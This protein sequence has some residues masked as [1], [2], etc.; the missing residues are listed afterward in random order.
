MSEKET[1]HRV[2]DGIFHLQRGLVPFVKGWVRKTH[3]KQ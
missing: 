2:Q 3:G 1:L